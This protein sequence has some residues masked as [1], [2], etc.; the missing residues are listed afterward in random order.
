[1]RQ[2]MRAVFL[3]ASSVVGIVATVLSIA[4]GNPY[5]L[6]VTAIGILAGIVGLIQ[7][8]RSVQALEKETRNLELVN[9]EIPDARTLKI[10]SQLVDC[11]YET[12]FR[13]GSFSDSI[14]TSS[15]INDLLR[16]GR[17]IE[18]KVNRG[19]FTPPL[20]SPIYF[21]LLNRFLSQDDKAFFDGKKVRLCTDL[22]VG[23]SGP[24]T[25]AI[26]KTRYFSTMVTNDSVG[27]ELVSRDHPKRKASFNGREFCFPGDEV[28][29][30]SESDC[31]NQIGAS[32]I[33]VTAD[34]HLV[35]LRQ[36]SGSTISPGKLAS[37][38][39]GSADWKDTRNCDSLQT[40]VKNVALRELQEECG[41]VDSDIGDFQILGFG[42]LL[43]RGGKPEF[44]C[45][46]RLRCD[47]SRIRVTRPEKHLTERHYPQL[48][49]LS[50]DSK[51]EAVRK[52][53]DKLLEDY[54]DE[55][56]TSLWWNLWFVR[57][58]PVDDLTAFLDRR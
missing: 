55:I 57:E 21:A 56:S 23:T 43:A 8:Y 40:L 3:L 29:P 38:G 5:L 26:E 9:I 14:L 2:K 12:M 50:S 13:K 10:G 39:S 17:R 49:D 48:L 47:Y 25:V 52:S 24:N 51:G 20:S 54:A 31:S 44:F 6:I 11:G 4:T 36:G 53:A 1:M 27:I 46:A 42:R 28:T 58:Y 41:L 18:L 19:R 35:I 37:S 30:C 7:T 32:T 16:D 45:I 15:R 34:D 33:A 22:L